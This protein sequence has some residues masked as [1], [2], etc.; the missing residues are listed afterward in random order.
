MP[1]TATSATAHHRLRSRRAGTSCRNGGKPLPGRQWPRSRRP[2]N[3]KNREMTKLAPPI[4]SRRHCR[5]GRHVRPG[6]GPAGTA[7]IRAGARARRRPDRQ[8]GSRP[9]NRDAAG[10]KAAGLDWYGRHNVGMPGTR[11]FA[12]SGLRCRRGEEPM[13]ALEPQAWLCAT[14]A[15]WQRRPIRQAAATRGRRVKERLQGSFVTSSA[16]TMRAMQPEIRNQ[17]QPD[18]PRTFTANAIWVMP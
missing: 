3:H 17:C 10:T 6:G 18:R 4:S 12:G 15:P 1:C 13:S 5:L 8:S 11:G 9:P 14:R 16:A 2:A 7:P